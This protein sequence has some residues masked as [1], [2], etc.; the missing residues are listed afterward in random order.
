MVAGFAILLL[1]GL[2]IDAGIT[3]RGIGEVIRG[4]LGRGFALA[5]LTMPTAL[6]ASPSGNQTAGLFS[7]GGN[8][9]GPLGLFEVFHDPLGHYWDSGQIHQ[10]AIGG[11]SDHVH[12]AGPTA[13]L[14]NLAALAQ[15]TFH[16]TVRQFPPYGP[17]T[18]V[19]VPGSYHYKHQAFDASG[20]AANMAAFA[21]YLIG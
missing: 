1:A 12:V 4:E 20:S 16:L 3:G 7:G 17:V 11:H 9:A 13:T 6:T 10:G 19:H 2:L 15:N 21:R 5:D 18:A 14:M 8:K